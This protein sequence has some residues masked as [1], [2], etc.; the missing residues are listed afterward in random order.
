MLII[1]VSS[2][3][4]IMII[5]IFIAIDL[6]YM[7]NTLVYVYKCLLFTHTCIMLH[8]CHLYIPVLYVNITILSVINPNTLHVPI[9]VFSVYIYWRTRHVL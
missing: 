7:Y 8:V 4:A 1:I 9:V 3:I 6:S 2:T 5:H